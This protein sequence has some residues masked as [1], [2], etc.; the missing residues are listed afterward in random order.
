MSTKVRQGVLVGVVALGITLSG[1]SVASAATKAEATGLTGTATKLVY[2]QPDVLGTREGSNSIT[3]T[4]NTAA[5]IEYPKITFPTGGR[6]ILLHPYLDGCASMSGGLTTIVCVT[7]PLAAGASRTLAVRWN[8][9]VGG[10]AGTAQAVVEQASDVSGTPIDGTDSSVSWKV[11]YEKLTGT[12]SIKATT[13]TFRDPATAGDV[14]D[15]TKVTIKNLSTETVQFPTVT[16]APYDGDAKIAD[17]KG[18]V[19]TFVNAAGTVCVEKPLAPGAKRTV[20]FPFNSAFGVWEYDGHVRVEAGAD[21]NGTVIPD[22][23]VGAMF[24][25]NSQGI[26]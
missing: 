8:S 25:I 19:A 6:D 26:D 14:T 16:F 7:E 13:L 21:A 23:A 20:E 24:L 3:I 2:G 22:T 18:C 9:Q 10:P 12:F 15:S 11:K 17:W 5:A 1:A 4:N